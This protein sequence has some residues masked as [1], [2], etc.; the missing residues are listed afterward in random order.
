MSTQRTYISNLE[1]RVSAHL[2]FHVQIEVLD[3]RRPKRGTYRSQPKYR[4]SAG[5][6]G[7]RIDSSPPLIEA[8]AH[9][10]HRRRTSRIGLHTH[11][12][13]VTRTIVKEPIEVD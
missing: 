4:L 9:V 3:V 5:A 12:T 10:Q 1:D 13:A 11:C 6:T 7:K 8:R 2:V